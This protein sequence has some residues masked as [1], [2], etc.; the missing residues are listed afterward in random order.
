M[1]IT[2]PG[3][4]CYSN[5]GGYP[6]AGD[7]ISH[8]DVSMVSDHHLKIDKSSIIS[9][10]MRYHINH[11]NADIPTPSSVPSTQLTPTGTP[12]V[13]I[14]NAFG[15]GYDVFALAQ[16]SA[17]SFDI[18]PRDQKQQSLDQGEVH[19]VWIITPKYPGQQQLY[20]AITGQWVPRSG[21]S[22]LTRPLG[23]LSETVVVDDLPQVDQVNPF[24]SMGQNLLLLLIGSVFSVPWIWD[25]VAKKREKERAT[26]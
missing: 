20:A 12:D 3:T 26:R 19:F 13:P 10:F 17:S 24:L 14:Q 22:S 9:I 6:I 23:S 8:L 16:L 1:H 21:G 4:C 15:Y 7:E 25:L 11:S 2:F 5:H 18:D